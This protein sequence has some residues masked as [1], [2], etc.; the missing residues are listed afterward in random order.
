[1]HRDFAQV[2]I[3]E[4]GHLRSGGRIRT[5]PEA[6]SAFACTLGPD[7]E[8][9]LEATV[10]TYAIVRLLQG[11]AGRV[12]VSNPLRTRAIADAKIKTDKVDA[13]V[14]VRLLAGGWLPDVWVP[15]DSTLTLRHQVAYRTSL[16]QQCTRLKNRIHAIL[17]RNLVPG[18]PQSD[19]FG[20]GGRRWLAQHALALLPPHEQAA[21]V[22]TLRELDLVGQEIATVEQTLAA[23]A[24]ERPQIRRLITIPGL[25][26]ISALAILAAIGDIHRF[27]AP[28]KLV[29]YLGLDPRV[30][31]SG[32]HRTTYGPI[33]KQGRGHARSTL[34]EAAWSAVQSPG[35][36]RAFYQ[37]LRRRRGP[38][39]AIVATARKLAVLVWY[40]LMREEDYAFA[41][42]SLVAHK[43]R[44]IELRAGFPK[45]SA[46]Q[47]L[48]SAYH[49]KEIQQ[50]ERAVCV[51]AERA[52]QRLTA[53][54]QSQRP[55]QHAG[56]TKGARR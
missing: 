19:L 4:Q 9:V 45:Q 48:A 33:S 39:V 20:K 14:L 38:Q 26:V 27:R 10:N 2:A 54:W 52:Y 31:Q 29:G 8:V 56:A 17:H 12:V 47:G 25:H 22:A 23:S 55:Q 6:L 1:V 50:Q 37:R 46:R 15:D 18:C 32:V 7:D 28:A 36:L 44:T 35:P 30:R 51:Q 13:E 41:R 16:V 53:R 43:M 21:V 3:L 5:T 11:H 49:R 24:L 42:P 34:V 40:V